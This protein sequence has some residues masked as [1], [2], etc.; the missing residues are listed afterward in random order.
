M[1]LL[2]PYFSTLGVQSEQRLIDDLVV[3]SIKVAGMKVYYLPRTLMREDPIFGEDVLSKFE[4]NYPIEMYFDS[5]SGFEGDKDILSKFGLEMRDRANFIVSRRRFNQIVRYNGAYMIPN[6]I[7]A[8]EEVRPM[9]GDLIYLPMTR[10]LFE[11]KWAAHEE[12]FYQLGQR[13][14]WRLTVEKFVYSNEQLNTGLDEV[15]WIE[16]RFSNARNPL[17]VLINDGHLKPE[18]GALKPGTDL[19]PNDPLQLNSTLTT[20]GNKII[21]FSE[22]NP[23]GEPKQ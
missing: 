11:I 23:F 17:D 8:E 10:D 22:D 18:D 16:G 3:E 5:A 1:A 2:N 12:V 15:D 21:D 19:T 4:K 9:E 6:P 20:E 13:Y 14:I 7:P